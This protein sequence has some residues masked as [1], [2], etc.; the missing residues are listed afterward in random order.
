MWID[1]TRLVGRKMKRYTE[2]QPRIIAKNGFRNWRLPFHLSQY[3]KKIARVSKQSKSQLRRRGNV[4]VYP[5]DICLQ[6]SQCWPTAP[7]LW[8]S[9]NSQFRGLE[10]TKWRV[11]FI[12]LS[13]ALVCALIIYLTLSLLHILQGFACTIGNCELGSMRK[14]AVT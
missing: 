12:T 10:Y 5:T 11:Y 8:A 14:E 9:A 7:I 3:I 1:G 6:N 13:L 2:R 4:P